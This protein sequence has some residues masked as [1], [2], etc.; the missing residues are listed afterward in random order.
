MTVFFSFIK[1]TWHDFYA[2]DEFNMKHVI[3][4]CGQVVQTPALHLGGHR[5]K[6]QPRDQVF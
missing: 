3:E 2:K 1:I 6:S 4:H 5:F